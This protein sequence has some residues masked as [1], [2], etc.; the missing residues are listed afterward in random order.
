M[1]LS[2]VVVAMFVMGAASAKALG[3]TIGARTTDA[4]IEL[5]SG[6]A[7]VLTKTVPLQAADPTGPARKP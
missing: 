6:T 2:L 3:H 5:R 1:E 7:V 4:S